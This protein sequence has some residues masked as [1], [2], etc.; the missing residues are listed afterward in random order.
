[1][2][3]PKVTKCDVINCAYNRNRT[4]H[5]LAI[6][7]GDTMRPKCDTFCESAEKGGDMDATARVGAC[8][9]ALCMHNN[10]LECAA[11][12]IEVGYQEAEPDCL[13]FER[14]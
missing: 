10:Q 4:C 12:G 9:M 11:V 6:T 3:M 7:I 14:Q 2:E 5:A 1:M 13:T 8:K